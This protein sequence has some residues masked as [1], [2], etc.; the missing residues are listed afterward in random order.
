MHEIVI[1]IHMHTRYSDGSGLHR[2]LAA[3]ALR[4]GLDAILVTDHNVLV[5]GVEGYQRQGTKR[6]LVL[7]GEEIHDQ[8]RVPQKNHMLVYGASRELAGL[9]DSPQALINSAR[10]EGAVTFIAHPYD[11]EQPSVGEP[12]I[13]WVDWEVQGY[14]GLE[15]WNGFSEFKGRLT[16]KLLGLFFTYFPQFVAVKPYPQ[17]VQIWDDL[18]ASGRRVAAIGGSDAHAMH[19]HLGPIHR[20][21]FPYEYHFRAV[22]TH[23]YLPEPLS[24]D[25]GTDRKLIVEALAAGRGFVGYD[26]PATT[27]GFRFTAQGKERSVMMGEEINAQGGITLQVH[28]PRMAGEIRL[29]KDGQLLKKWTNTTTA[30]HITTEPG[31]YRVE[32][33]RRYLGR[34][35]AWVFSNPIY[36]R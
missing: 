2:D 32:A 33:Y 15:L 3:A 4:A 19:V 36:V 16:S 11:P 14:T 24:G 22:N 23:L 7:V 28:A 20:T 31:I 30:T 12:N 5:Q 13:S 21:L 27:R 6:V 34:M 8:D 29:L 17:A 10:S 25:V 18:L 26:L 9:A 35:R 1:N